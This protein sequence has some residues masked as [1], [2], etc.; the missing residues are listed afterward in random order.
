MNLRLT[1]QHT[2]EIVWESGDRD[3]LQA[4]WLMIVE[5][6]RRK[7]DRWIYDQV[8]VRMERFYDTLHDIGNWIM[9]AEYRRYATYTPAYSGWVYWLANKVYRFKTWL[10]Y[11]TTWRHLPF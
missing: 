11:R 2:G 7:P 10:A 5:E 8:C 9:H 3:V 4:A 6:I 1:D